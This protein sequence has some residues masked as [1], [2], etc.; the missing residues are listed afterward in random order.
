MAGTGKVIYS[1]TSFALII[2]QEWQ[3]YYMDL[4]KKLDCPIKGINE[5][6]EHGS[7]SARR[8]TTTNGI[9]TSIHGQYVGPVENYYYKVKWFYQENEDANE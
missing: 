4:Y 9:A 5:I 3:G 7:H 6:D 8:I 1:G 2:G